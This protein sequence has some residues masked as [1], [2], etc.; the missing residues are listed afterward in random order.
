VNDEIIP[1]TEIPATLFEHAIKD[2]A[3]YSIGFA[4]VK[5]GPRRQEVFL[6]GS[7][8][9][10]AVGE[11]RA[12]LTAD[13][14][15]EKL[16]RDGRLGLI[17]SPSR[18][19][20]T[21]DTRGLV[22]LRIARGTDD[23]KGPDLGA[24][25]LSPS[26]ASSIGAIKTF[27]NLDIRR[28]RMLSASPDR[29]LGAWAVHGF[30]D[31]RTVEE[32]GDSGFNHIMRFYCLTGWGGPDPAVSNGGYDYHTFPVSYGGRSVAPVSFKG[33]SGGG[34]WQV[35]LVR[36]AQGILTHRALLLAGLVFYQVP[37]SET[38]AGV[39]CHGAVSIY[40]IA[41]DAIQTSAT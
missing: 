21:I 27:Y 2:I 19:Q 39:T 15:V 30:I 33:M 16:P 6:R 24:V 3:N 13:H 28:E 14:V 31:E 20:Y 4:E 41:Y 17:L 7:G 18:Q 1:L 26:I 37:T 36:D 22:F 38:E 35:P 40:R 11:K 34:L 23:S 9:L 25:I 5:N 29:D 12:I 32:P 10:I 8:T